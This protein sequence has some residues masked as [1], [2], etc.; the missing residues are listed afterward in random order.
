[1]NS[2]LRYLEKCKNVKYGVTS[3]NQAQQLRTEA[4][5]KFIN[6]DINYDELIKLL[7]ES[8]E[9]L[10]NSIAAEVSLDVTRAENL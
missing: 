6:H 2:S 5:L 1:M 7:K 10:I 4:R 3:I 9:I 8:N